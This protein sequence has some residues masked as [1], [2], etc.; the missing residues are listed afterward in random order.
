MTRHTVAPGER[1]QIVW[2]DEGADD[3]PAVV[4][5]LVRTESGRLP[6]PRRSLRA[7][8]NYYSGCFAPLIAPGRDPVEIA[9]ALA[10]ALV[11]EAGAWDSLDL[12][13]MDPDAPI[14]AALIERLR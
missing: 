1:L 6:L 3:A 2:A 8:S 4:L 7:L 10:R 9:D 5:P 11:E 13:P 14:F 12:S